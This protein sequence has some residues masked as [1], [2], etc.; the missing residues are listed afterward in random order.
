MTSNEHILDPV[1]DEDV[2]KV[3]DAVAVGEDLEFQERWWTFE[4]VIWIFFTLILIADALGVFGAGWLAHRKVTPSNSGMSIYY[5]RVLRVGTPTML[6]IQFGP[7]AI[8]DT[9]V[10]LDVSASVTKEL[11]AQ[12]VIPQPLTSVIQS[13]HVTYTFP[14]SNRPGEVQFELQPGSPGYRSFKLQVPGHNPVEEHVL[15]LP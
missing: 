8:K 1:L 2:P 9:E 3:D 6:G 15:V 7:D 11:G 14:A 10:T 4:R 12:R 13:G 5:D